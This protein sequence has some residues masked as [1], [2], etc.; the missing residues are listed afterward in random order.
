M[1]NLDQSLMEE[2]PG[3]FAEV[4]G[5]GRGGGGPR[6]G[7]PLEAERISTVPQSREK[8]QA[9]LQDDMQQWAD[10]LDETLERERRLN[11]DQRPAPTVEGGEEGTPSSPDQAP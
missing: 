7:L 6:G 2:A 1:Q 11:L 8:L 4:Q 3:T 9:L 10:I 5:P